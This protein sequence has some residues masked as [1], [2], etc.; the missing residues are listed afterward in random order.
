MACFE[1]P[2]MPDRPQRL[3]WS[4]LLARVFGTDLS[5]RRGPQRR[6]R[7][8]MQP[9][10]CPC[11]GRRKMVAF[12][13]ESREATEILE[14]LGID[15]TAPPVAAARAPPRQLEAF[16]AAPDYDGVDAQYP[17]VA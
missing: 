3:L 9:L 7:L 10:G 1:V 15:A 2:P 11:G 5:N 6:S 12:I 16:E 14:R 4:D 8:G 17:D 13:P